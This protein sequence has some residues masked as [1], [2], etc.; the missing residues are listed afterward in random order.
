MGGEVTT[1][2]DAADGARRIDCAL[3]GDLFRMLLKINWY[4][5]G[6]Y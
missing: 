3:D 4:H 6:L 5:I 2:A 1:I